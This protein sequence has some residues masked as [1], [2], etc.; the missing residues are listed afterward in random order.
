RR[1]LEEMLAEFHA[2]NEVGLA[3]WAQ[4]ALAR[5]E[6]DAGTNF[7]ENVLSEDADGD[8][9]DDTIRTAPVR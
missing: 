2:T 5:I 4:D 3:T 1:E 6:R 9:D 8:P 7:I